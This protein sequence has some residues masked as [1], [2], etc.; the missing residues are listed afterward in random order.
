VCAVLVSVATTGACIGGGGDGAERLEAALQRALPDR[1][2]TDTPIW[3]EGRLVISGHFE[4]KASDGLWRVEVQRSSMVRS[5]GAMRVVDERSWRADEKAGT[6]DAHTES[7]TDRFEGV[8]DGARWVKRRGHGPWIE[9]DTSDGHHRA[10]QQRVRDW[11]PEL[12]AAFAHGL[13]RVPTADPAVVIGGREASWYRLTRAS[14]P[15]PAPEEPLEALRDDER[16]WPRW[17]A[18]TH[19]IQAASGRIAVSVEPPHEVLAGEMDVT[20]VTVVEGREYAFSA[21][22]NHAWT[23]EVDPAELVLPESWLPADRQRVWPMIRE[24]L[25]DGLSPRWGGAAV[26]P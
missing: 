14:R 7:N 11:L 20:G 25:G 26:A 5:D 2:P 6:P 17:F 3:P 4:L 23:P 12:V 9:R 15:Q 1:A 24:V 18:A 19:T 22:A 16:A 13:E 8:F 10:T 21:A